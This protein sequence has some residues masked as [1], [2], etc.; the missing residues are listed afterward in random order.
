MKL[1]F[2]E[3][4]PNLKH[5]ELICLTFALLPG[6]VIFGSCLWGLPLLLWSFIKLKNKIKVTYLLAI[7]LYVI[8]STPYQ[9]P[10][11]S[12]ALVIYIGYLFFKDKKLNKGLLL[13]FLVFNSLGILL[14]FGL[15][16]S[17]IT[18]NVE[19]I[20]HRTNNLS[21]VIYPSING[22]IYQY[23]KVL[24]FENLTLHNSLLYQ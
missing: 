13:G 23:F 16:I 5:K 17:S 11:I 3:L 7:I 10:Y 6:M 21:D 22:I 12:L 4:Y 14:D 19:L 9:Y 20:S 1:L 18:N 15:L 8:S 2:K 24:I